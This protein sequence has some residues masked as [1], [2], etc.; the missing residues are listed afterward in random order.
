MQGSIS[1]IL[2]VGVAMYGDLTL[3][4]RCAKRPDISQPTA[5]MKQFKFHKPPTLTAAALPRWLDGQ[6]RSAEH[7]GE[8]LIVASHHA[9]G[10]GSAKPELMAW[11]WEELQAKLLAC[12]SFVIAFAGG[13]VRGDSQLRPQGYLGMPM[14][15]KFH[16]I[17]SLRVHSLFGRSYMPQPL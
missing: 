2:L 1:I 11:N 13:W 4:L 8:R 10:Q 12:R 15:V 16:I 6:L 9:I 3:Q 14:S 7:L 5:I 17:G